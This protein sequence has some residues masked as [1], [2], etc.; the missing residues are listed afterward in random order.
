VSCCDYPTRGGCSQASVAAIFTPFARILSTTQRE[1]YN[2]LGLAI[3]AG[4]FHMHRG[5]VELSNREGGGCA[6]FSAC[7]CEPQPLIA[8]WVSCL[9]DAAIDGPSHLQTNPHR[10]D[11]LARLLSSSRMIDPR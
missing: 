10:T 4:A 3:V 11:A 1:A 8:Q 2:R 7:G 5:Q 6:W 9:V